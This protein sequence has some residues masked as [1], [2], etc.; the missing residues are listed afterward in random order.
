MC[1]ITYVALKKLWYQSIKKL[2][3]ILINFWYYN[4]QVTVVYQTGIFPK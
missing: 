1:H 2:L 3:K 4:N